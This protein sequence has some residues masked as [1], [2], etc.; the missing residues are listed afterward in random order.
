MIRNSLNPL[1]ILCILIVMD[2]HFIDNA[3]HEILGLF[4]VMLFF[5]H[6]ALN[7]QWY[8]AIG[9]VKMDLLRILNT[10]TNL[11]L[12]VMTFLVSV[13]GVLISQTV[14]SSFS[15][16]DNLLAHQLH[17]LSAY[18]GFILSAIHLGFH[19]NAL[20]GKL[21]RWLR[22]DRMRSSYI[23]LSRIV[24][25]LTVCYGIYASFTRHIG[26]K[27]LLQHGF[28]DWTAAPSLVDFLFNY[29]AIM[30]CYIAIAHYLSQLLQYP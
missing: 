29:M 28:N 20:R 23:L 16:S 8:T 2:Y 9:K 27:L 26:A 25:L 17:I 11:L 30:G 5:I 3:I 10:I 21:C 24:L 12:L 6:N 13:T 7:R 15:L 18:L 14:F 22:I 19:W 1:M 4:I